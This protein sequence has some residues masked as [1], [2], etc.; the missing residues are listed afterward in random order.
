MAIA[1]YD[2]LNTTKEN[3]DLVTSTIRNVEISFPQFYR[4]PYVPPFFFTNTL[5]EV[6]IEIRWVS[7]SDSRPY[8]VSS[9][10]LKAI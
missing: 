10:I 3:T 1:T 5:T 4:A 7:E 2:Y 6:L 8:V 9:S